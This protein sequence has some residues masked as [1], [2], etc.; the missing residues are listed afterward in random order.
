VLIADVSE[1]IEGS[2]TSAISTQTQGKH[3]K[4]N[5]L[6][7]IYQEGSDFLRSVGISM[8]WNT[9]V[10][11][12]EEQSLHINCSDVAVAVFIIIIIVIDS[13][14]LLSVHLSG[15]LYLSQTIGGARLSEE[16][17]SSYP[18][19]SRGVSQEF[20]LYMARLKLCWVLPQS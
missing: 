7:I 3:P 6:H 5:I 11:Y 8:C 10:R 4:E 2:E 17:N 1:P 16:G 14:T 19:G 18:L 13:V 15:N 20:A 12:P 9:R